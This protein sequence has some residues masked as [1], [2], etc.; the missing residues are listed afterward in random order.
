M[1]DTSFRFNE[2]HSLVNQ[3]ETG[4]DRVHVKT[5]LSN[6]NGGVTLL[7]FEAGQKLEEHVAPAEVMVYTIE[8][9]V[10][11]NIQGK[12]HNLAAGNFLLL[13]QGTPHSVFAREHSKVMLIKVKA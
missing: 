3:I 10:E 5:I 8:G 7:A 11:F 6:S 2:V 1:T 13:E 12:T 9:S 4:S